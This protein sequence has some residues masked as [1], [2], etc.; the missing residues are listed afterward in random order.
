MIN[1]EY[2][3]TAN[4][5]SRHGFKLCLDVYKKYNGRCDLCG[6]EN[7]L[8]IH[9]LDGNGR[10]LENIGSQPN[11]ELS[12]LQLLCRKCHGKLHGSAEWKYRNNHREIF[13]KKKYFKEYQETNRDAIR[14]QHRNYY[15]KNKAKYVIGGIYYKKYQ[16]KEK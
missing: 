13:D 10:N 1:K 3:I 2:G 4:Q 11:N 8:A 9:H 7:F 12:N 16:A 6:S 14:E 5:I 15:L